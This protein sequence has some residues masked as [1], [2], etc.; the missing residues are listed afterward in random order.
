[1]HGLGDNLYQRAVLSMVGDMN[2]YLRTPWPQLYIDLP[3][4]LLPVPSSLRTQAKNLRAVKNYWSEE[5]KEAKQI[6]FAYT[7]DSK[8]IVDSLWESLGFSCVTPNFFPPI[9]GPRPIKERYII[10]RPATVRTEW[11]A[12]ARNPKQEYL[13]MA[14]RRLAKTHRIISVADLSDGEWLDGEEPFAHEK[15]HSGSSLEELLTLVSHC[16]G[17]IGGVGW[18]VPA[19]LTFDKPMFLVYG[20]S[21]FYN[22][23]N[24]I[25]SNCGY[26]QIFE[27]FPDK[28]CNCKHMV[29]N[30]DKTVSDI[31][32]QIDTWAKKIQRTKL[33]S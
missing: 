18:A 33:V 3:I 10:L 27:V 15:R 12:P 30:C 32:A 5:P 16:D 28:F 19:A 21:G 22:G 7:G 1:M 24:K 13:D 9:A 23:P 20:G 2:T 17:I 4:R 29:H 25:L 26:N 6:R 8:S 31:E 14:A 11:E